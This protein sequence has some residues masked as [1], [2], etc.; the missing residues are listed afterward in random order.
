MTISATLISLSGMQASQQRVSA[1]AS[2]VANQFSTSRM[3]PDG[4][5]E[6]KPYQ[7]IESVN[8]SEPGGG[9][10]STTRPVSPESFPAFLPT[11]PASNEEG[12]VELPNV[13]L[14][15]EM[16]NQILGKR[17]FEFN[18]E[19]LKASDENTQKLLDS[20]A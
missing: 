5:V 7:P 9:V 15:N 6:N 1:S 2:N 20:I 17:A 8:T 18:L 4:T 14:A 19:V 11:N 13:D 16:V 12:M 3:N 10:S